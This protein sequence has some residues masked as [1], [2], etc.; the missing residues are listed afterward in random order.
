[1]TS[2]STGVISEQ[3]ALLC[4]SDHT[5][6][7]HPSSHSFSE[8]AQIVSPGPHSCPTSSVPFSPGD[9]PYPPGSP[10]KENVGHLSGQRLSLRDS[11]QFGWKTRN[12]HGAT[13]VPKV[14]HCSD[15]EDWDLGRRRAPRGSCQ[16]DS[17]VLWGEGAQEK[18]RMGTVGR[19]DSWAGR[20]AQD[21]SA[22]LP[23]GCVTQASSF[24]HL[25]ETRG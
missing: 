20:L 13:G 9:T 24:P 22:V 6:A 7:N 2:E 14:C 8:A 5:L 18:S 11:H 12:S 15:G 1:M 25:R 19:K 16:R 3:W 21:G 10:C 4:T 23:L 17:S